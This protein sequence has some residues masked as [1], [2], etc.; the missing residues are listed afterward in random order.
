MHEDVVTSE[1]DK[2]SMFFVLCVSTIIFVLHG[3]RDDIR[4]AEDMLRSAHI[5]P[6]IETI[7]IVFTILLFRDFIIGLM[8]YFVSYLLFSRPTLALTAYSGGNI[9][10]AAGRG[11]RARA[12][13][14]IVQS[15]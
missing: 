15:I 10:S 13:G 4:E 11:R 2:P 8:I 5:S 3:L 1:I 6:T 7:L 12:L 9:I 14:K